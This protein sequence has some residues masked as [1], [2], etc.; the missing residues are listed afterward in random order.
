M[1]ETDANAVKRKFSRDLMRLPGVIGV[2][3]EKTSHDSFGITVF[4]TE[5]NLKSKA[6]LPADLD[7][8]PYRV[9]ISGPIRPQ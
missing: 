5:D 3:V 1:S 6:V 9:E 2:G 4:L 7:G 8:H